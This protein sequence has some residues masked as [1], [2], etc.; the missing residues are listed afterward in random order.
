MVGIEPSCVA[1][2]RDELPNM[3]PHDED[4]RRLSQQTLTLDEFL[5]QEARNYE[6]PEIN[7]KAIVHGR[8]HQEAIMKMTAEQELLTKLGLD[9]E[10]LDS[11][12]CGLAGSFGFEKGHY[13]ISMKVGER[14]LLPAA[15]NAEK[16][17]LIIADGFSC[18]T[19]IEHAAD[20]RALHTAQVIRM[21]MQ[22]RE[23]GPEGDYPER[24]YPDVVLDGRVGADF[25]P[26]PTL[27]AVGVAVAS[28]AA[29]AS[30]LKRRFG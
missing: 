6:P 9:F 5:V 23:N 4:A 28:G 30:A 12:C 10:I 26:S 25:K 22:H 24:G 11:G 20:R 27:A 7:R 15:R 21:A 29:L 19:Q 3:L 2:F 16:D 18:K 1:T 13:D 14:W 17:T 8:C